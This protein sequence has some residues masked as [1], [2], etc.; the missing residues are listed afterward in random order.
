MQL[1]SPA[2]SDSDTIP[3]R[4]T[5]DGANVSPPLQWREPP[6]GTQTFA[7][8]VEDPDAPRRTFTHWV[9]YDI[10][11]TLHQLS[12]G[13]AHTAKLLDGAIQGKNDFG[14]LG[15]GGPCPPSGTHRYFFNLH[16]LDQ[17]LNLKPGAS[18]ADVLARMKGHILQT[19]SLVGLYSR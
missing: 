19:V 1:Q 7:L 2:F 14:Q 15:Y 9:I 17:P 3:F 4:Y 13:V 10:P 18:K 5:C 8:I 11:A 16:A 12:E 6:M